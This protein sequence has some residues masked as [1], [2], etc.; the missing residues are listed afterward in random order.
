[1]E[2]KREVIWDIVKGI[3]IVSIV[4]G[5]TVPNSIIHEFVYMYH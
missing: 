4:I 3:G 2:K 5:H 1:M